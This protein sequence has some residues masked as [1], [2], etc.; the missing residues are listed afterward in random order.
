[1]AR[2]LSASR[3]GTTDSTA[4][5]L[6][7]VLFVLVAMVVQTLPRAYGQSPSDYDRSKEKI[8]ALAGELKAG[9]ESKDGPT[10]SV[11]G[12]RAGK[13]SAAMK[14]KLPAIRATVEART[15]IHRPTPPKI[16]KAKVLMHIKGQEGIP[17]VANP[18]YRGLSPLGRDGVDY[19]RGVTNLLRASTDAPAFGPC[20][21]DLRESTPRPTLQPGRYAQL[22]GLPKVLHDTLYLARTDLPS[23]PAEAFGQ[24][25]SI[26]V[27]DEKGKSAAISARSAG[28]RCLPTRFIVTAKAVHRLQGLHAL[29][30]YDKEPDGE[31]V[32]NPVI[33][34]KKGIRRR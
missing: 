33:A 1:M 28:V 4:V 9:V 29:K 30:N 10:G 14:V 24:R 21:K 18:G 19:R 22:K 27:V 12:D 17:F 5:N 13:F 32:L 11:Q 16:V 6:L 3:G 20:R 8:R 23:D 25:T 2:A 34:I 26:R 15:G 31:G 7:Q